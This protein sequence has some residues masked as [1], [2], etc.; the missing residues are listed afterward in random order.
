M[1]FAVTVGFAWRGSS[2]TPTELEGPVQAI[3][4]SAAT[5]EITGERA[6]ELVPTW[7]EPVLLYSPGGWSGVVT[8][9]TGSGQE[10]GN[11]DVLLELN[12]IGVIASTSG[13]FY[14]NLKRGDT[15]NDVVELQELLFALDLYSGEISGSFGADTALAVRDLSSHLGL[16]PS[17]GVFSP[18]WTVFL[19]SSPLPGIQAGVAVAQNAPAGGVEI[20]RSSPMLAAV[21]I[22]DPDTGGPV[23]LEGEWILSTQG[24]EIGL[25]NGD[26]AGGWAAHVQVLGDTPSDGDGAERSAGLVRRTVPRVI[27]TVPVSAVRADGEGRTC[28]FTRSDRAQD[29]FEPVQVTVGESIGV[30][31]EI[32]SGLEGSEPILAN[33]AEFLPAQTSC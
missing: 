13:P 22:T 28:V 11:G 1:V 8:S 23:T 17:V 5:A 31:I 19:P 14:R 25:D 30:S 4:V 29:S 12:D 2:R 24:L 16:S 10:I 7:S 3:V 6:V 20:A 26:P 33:Q 18:A 9:V 32:R 21:E 27:N 15:G